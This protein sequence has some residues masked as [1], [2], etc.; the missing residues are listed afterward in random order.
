MAPTDLP[1]RPTTDMAK[2]SLFNI[3]VNTLDFQ[4]IEVLDLFAGTGNI[5]YEFAS[6][7]CPQVTAVDISYRCTS[8]IRQV[9][10]R[11][12]FAAITVIQADYKKFIKQSHRSW[13]LVFADPPYNMDGIR[14]IPDLIFDHGMLVKNGLLIIE[15]DRQ[16]EFSNHPFFRQQRKYGKVNFSFFENIKSESF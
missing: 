8:F 7:G 11:L 16:I 2:E 10:I 12:Q 3:L 5:S 9:A 13:G 14:E 4:Q 15:H 1:V 6:R